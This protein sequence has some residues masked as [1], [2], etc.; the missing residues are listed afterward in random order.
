VEVTVAFPEPI[1]V[2]TH[3]RLPGA[4]LGIQTTDPGELQVSVTGVL[5][6]ALVGLA[7]MAV[8]PCTLTCVVA[9]KAWAPLPH[10]TV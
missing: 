9:W 3:S 7:E 2:P 10:V 8:T 5:T 6:G 4:P 1:R